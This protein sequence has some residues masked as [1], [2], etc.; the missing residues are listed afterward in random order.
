MIETDGQ[1]CAL[2]GP[3]EPWYRRAW[4]RAFPGGEARPGAFLS[5]PSRG[6]V[7]VS[8]TPDWDYWW[9]DYQGVR[10]PANQMGNT[11]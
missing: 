8:A 3:W 5:I 11:A 9:F 4:R 1:G 2:P 6:L 7:W 10:P